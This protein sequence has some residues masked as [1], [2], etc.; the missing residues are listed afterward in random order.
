MNN[1]KKV[2]LAGL[3]IAIGVVLARFLS[4]KM[5]I[6][7]ISLSFVPIMLSAIVLGPWWTMVVSGLVDLI[8]ALLFPF[9]AYFVGYTITAALSGLT[10][11][12]FIYKKKPL[13]KKKFIVRLLIAVVIVNLIFNL[14]FNSLWIYIQTKKAAIAFMPT[15]IVSE[16]V[17]IAVKV[18]VMFLLDLGLEKMGAY[19]L[20]LNNEVENIESESDEAPASDELETTNENNVQD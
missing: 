3:L 18:V 9:G 7:T 10:Y 8:G 2:I 17:M 15:R 4:I 13:S 1:L 19:K 16:F 12:L 5:T 11:G 14:G 6:L 20:F